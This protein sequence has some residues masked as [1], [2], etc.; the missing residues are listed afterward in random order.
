MGSEMCI[1]DS[2]KAIPGVSMV[3]RVDPVVFAALGVRV[4]GHKL[5]LV[6]AIT[7]LQHA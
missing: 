7:A 2:N 4:L 5:M 6:K 3:Q 1:R